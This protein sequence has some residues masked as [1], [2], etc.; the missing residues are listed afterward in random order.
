MLWLV[1]KAQQRAD[2]HR[3]LDLGLADHDRDI[4]RPASPAAPHRRA[5]PSP[6]SRGSSTDRRETTSSATLISVDI[7]P[8]PRL[9]RRGRRPSCRR[10]RCRGGWWSPVANS[11]ASSRVVLP[12]RYGPI[13]AAQ[14][15]AAVADMLAMGASNH[16]CQASAGFSQRPDGTRCVRQSG[17]AGGCNAIEI[18]PTQRWRRVRGRPS[19]RRACSRR[20]AFTAARFP[21]T[22]RPRRRKN[23][24]HRVCLTDRP[25]AHA[26]SELP[27][28]YQTGW[29]RTFLVAL[30][31]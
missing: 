22:P 14:R 21:G 2:R 24:A 3:A 23:A 27:E 17:A 19:H 4:A 29:R 12:D 8:R 1:E 15:G 5:R 16:L 10:A 20:R 18:W 7:W 6:G 31:P 30:R 11:S 9:G 25:P 26:P 28:R 13:S